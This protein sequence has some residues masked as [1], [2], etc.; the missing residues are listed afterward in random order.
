MR[1]TSTGE[2]NG[3]CAVKLVR[4]Y[5][6]YHPTLRVGAK[7]MAKLPAG[8]WAGK[9]DK[10][11]TVEFD[12]GEDGPIET[13]VPLFDLEVTDEA[14]LSAKG[15]LRASLLAAVDS[16]TARGELKL[17]ARGTFQKL[18]V[19]FEHEG[20]SVT[21]FWVRAVD[22]EEVLAA[23]RAKGLVK[24]QTERHARRGSFYR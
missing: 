12:G 3:L 14:W 17:S 7:G 13:E 22:C 2:T 9:L 16:G 19:T 24:E 10:Y 1:P 4:D 20:R 15:R 6:A 21:D 5:T 18:S 8:K 23:L 11:V